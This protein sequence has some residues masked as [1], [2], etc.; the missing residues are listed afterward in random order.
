M[1][2]FLRA[3]G[4]CFG[5][6]IGG[7]VFQNALARELGTHAGLA[8]V[9]GEYAKDAVTLVQLIKR[10]PDSPVRRA[11]MQS[12]ADALKMVWISMAAFAA[13]GMI[14]SLFTEKLSL[15][16]VFESEQNIRAKKKPSEKARDA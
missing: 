12:Y 4:Q 13:A 9:A 2:S 1:F 5:V 7:V 14:A 6:A 16:R 11:L 8:A 15:D 3:F 10:M